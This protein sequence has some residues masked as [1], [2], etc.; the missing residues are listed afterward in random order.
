MELYYAFWRGKGFYEW[1]VNPPKSSVSSDL[2][3]VTMGGA[4]IRPLL[5]ENF[6]NINNDLAD[7]IIAEVLPGDRNRFYCYLSNQPLGLGIIT[8]GPGFGKTTA[9]TT[10][11]FALGAKYG[12]ILYSGPSNVLVDNFAERLNRVTYSVTVTMNQGKGQYSRTTH[13]LIVCEYKIKDE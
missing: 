4:Q 2:A 12:P 10:A 8:A 7:A 3:V 9:L 13:S 6:L 1:M 11:I 5:V